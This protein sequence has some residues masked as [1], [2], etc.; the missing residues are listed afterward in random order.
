MSLFQCEECGCIDNTALS[1]QGFKYSHPY[2][3]WTGIEDRRGKMLCCACGPTLYSDGVVSKYGV[4]HGNHER[5][6]F[7]K[8]KYFTN[9][10]GNVEHKETGEVV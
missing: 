8:G 10:E 5:V 3:D 4:W 1:S 6:F 7:E 2:F 9:K